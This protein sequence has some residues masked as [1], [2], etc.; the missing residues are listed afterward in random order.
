MPA[1]YAVSAA[2]IDDAD[3]RYWLLDC[4]PDFKDQYQILQQHAGEKPK[5]RTIL[6]ASD[7]LVEQL[8]GLSRS[9]KGASAGAP[10]MY[11][12]QTTDLT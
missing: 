8:P 9:T 7:L 1:Q 6:G 10:Y 2:I 4:S 11:F 5:V 12:T 3:K